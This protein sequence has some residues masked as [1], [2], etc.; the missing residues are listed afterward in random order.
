MPTPRA[1]LPGLPVGDDMLA[2]PGANLALGSAYLAGLMKEFGEPR[3]AVAAYNAGPA[4]V[5]EWWKGRATDDLE[6][7]VE[8][9]PFDETRFFVRR[10]MLSWEEYRR[11][12]APHGGRPVTMPV[13]AGL[14]AAVTSIPDGSRLLLCSMWLVIG[15]ALENASD[16]ETWRC[17]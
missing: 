14:P 15:P 10:V 1:S 4:R 3:L 11:S 12:T 9:I 16:L 7:W 8:L 5:R 13:T 17:A 2:D 6:V